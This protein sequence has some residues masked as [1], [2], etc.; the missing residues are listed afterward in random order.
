MRLPAIYIPHGGGPWPFVDVRFASKEEWAPLEA[1][2][3]SLVSSL[4][5]RPRALLV[6]SAHWE[7]Q[8]ATL[9]T[10]PHPP[11]LYDYVGFAPAA[12][13]LQWPAPTAIALVPRVRSLLE[14]AGIPSAED[15]KRGFD[16]GTFIPMMLSVPDADIP[17]LQVS[18]FSS[19]D[20][21]AHLALG[22]AL[23]P[24]RDEGVLIIG[25]GSSFHNLRRFGP[26]SAEPS[27]TF[28]AWLGDA[29]ALSRPERDERLRNWRAAPGGPDCHPREEHLLPLHVVAGAAGEDVGSVPLRTEIAGCR[30]SAVHFG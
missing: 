17:I 6:V 13:E 4:P 8:T 19:L 16:H 15:G 9:M 3:R 12:Y 18:L 27:R 25:S 21:E 30:V 23:A 29:V 7:E 11:M 26:M 24:L 10:A 14:A 28:D 1:Y 20:P 2:L 5:E 22:R